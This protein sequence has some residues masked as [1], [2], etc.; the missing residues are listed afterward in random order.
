MLRFCRVLLILAGSFA[1]S[2]C[3]LRAASAVRTFP[4]RCP[5]GWQFLYTDHEMAHGGDRPEAVCRQ[6]PDSVARVGAH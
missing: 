2:A 1:A 5:S 6:E 3:A 4:D